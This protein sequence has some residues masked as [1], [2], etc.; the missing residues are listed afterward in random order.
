MTAP[1]RPLT[2]LEVHSPAFWTLLFEAAGLPD[3]ALSVIRDRELPTLHVVGAVTDRVL[4]FAA[5]E[6]QHARIE[7]HYIAVADDARGSGLGRRL[8][9]SA[10]ALAPALPLYASTDDDAVGFY[11]SLGFAVTDAPRDARWPE[12]PRYHCT[13]VALDERRRRAAA[14]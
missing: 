8:V 11:R 10:R 3:D 13:I 12:R 5:F 2:A 9:T 1:I 14:V 7:L 6:V 4:G